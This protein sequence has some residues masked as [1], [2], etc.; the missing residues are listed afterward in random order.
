[1]RIAARILEGTHNTFPISLLFLYHQSRCHA[2]FLLRYSDRYNCGSIERVDCY[3]RRGRSSR[4]D[5]R[6]CTCKHAEREKRDERD[7]CISYDTH[8]FP[9]R[10]ASI[11]TVLWFFRYTLG[12]IIGERER[13][14]S[15]G[16]AG[17][18]SDNSCSSPGDGRRRTGACTPR[19][20]VFPAETS[21]SKA[22]RWMAISQGDFSREISVFSVQPSWCNKTAFAVRFSCN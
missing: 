14:W 11:C 2:L 4:Q 20:I 8:L 12:P 15:T 3:L 21:Y 16:Y 6:N 10:R 7:T 13:R 1:M 19:T 5:V 22:A 17:A 18:S 9:S